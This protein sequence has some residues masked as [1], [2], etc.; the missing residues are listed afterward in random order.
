[1]VWSYADLGALLLGS[2]R[3]PLAYH[4][5]GSL[6]RPEKFSSTLNS[7]F[8][9]EAGHPARAKEVPCGARFHSSPHLLYTGGSI[10]P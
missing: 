10:H 6:C 7:R 3:D 4:G 1:M 2:L 9:W 5:P 8:E